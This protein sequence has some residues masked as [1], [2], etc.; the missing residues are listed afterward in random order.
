MDKDKAQVDK[1]VHEF[2]AVTS[3]VPRQA[4]AG[5]KSAEKYPEPKARLSTLE[6][7]WPAA[8]PRAQRQSHA[9]ASGLLGLVVVLLYS[10]GPDP[11]VV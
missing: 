9:W 5:D 1:I 10:R 7:L 4:Y 8:L 2:A 6:N 11:V 3:A